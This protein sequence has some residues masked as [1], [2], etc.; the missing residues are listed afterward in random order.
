MFSKIQG[1]VISYPVQCL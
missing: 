1:K